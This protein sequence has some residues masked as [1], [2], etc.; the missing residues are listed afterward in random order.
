MQEEEGTTLQE[1]GEEEG[2]LCHPCG[3]CCES[4]LNEIKNR[5]L[6]LSL[7][8]LAPTTIT[9]VAI[10]TTTIRAAATILA[11]TTTS[12]T[13]SP[14]ISPSIKKIMMSILVS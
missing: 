7:P 5:Q 4:N 2:W 13:T 10:I 9:A 8:A 14:Q 6:I 1:V 3:E 11:A 12:L